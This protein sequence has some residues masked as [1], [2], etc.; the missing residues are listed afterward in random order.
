MAIGNLYIIIGKHQSIPVP[1]LVLRE[2]LGIPRNAVDD[3]NVPVPTIY[4]VLTQIQVD[5]CFGVGGGATWIVFHS[6]EL[7]MSVFVNETVELFNTQVCMYSH[8]AICYRQPSLHEGKA[9]SYTAH[10]IY[11]IIYVTNKLL[12]WGVLSSYLYILYHA[13]AHKGSS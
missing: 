3:S 7:H 4:V 10:Q 9:V 2:H 1:N 12:F 5:G 6:D 11:T 8:S 13:V